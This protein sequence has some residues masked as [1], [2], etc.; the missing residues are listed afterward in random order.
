MYELHV[1]ADSPGLLE[2]SLRVLRQLALE[3]RA[4]LVLQRASLAPGVAAVAPSF[5]LPQLLRKTPPNA[6]FRALLG[7]ACALLGGLGYSPSRAPSCSCFG[8]L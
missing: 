3:V 6:V 2:R 1:P 4:R 7:H 8:S 5:D